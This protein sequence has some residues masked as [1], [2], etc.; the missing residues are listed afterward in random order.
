MK[1]VTVS[2]VLF[3]ATGCAQGATTPKMP[4][5]G[6]PPRAWRTMSDEPTPAGVIVRYRANHMQAL[7]NDEGRS[8]ALPRMRVFDAPDAAAAKA[9]LERLCKDPAIEA[10]EPDYRL[11]A[12]DLP[13]DPQLGAQ[14]GVPKMQVPEGWAHSTG[15]GAT[16]AVVDTGVHA[17][18]PDLG[19]QIIRGRDCVNDDDDPSDDH[20]HGTHVAGTIAALANNGLGGVG[21]APQS[22][23]L[24][25]KVLDQNGSGRTSD[26]AEG[27]VY[28]AEQGAKVINLSLG[29][30]QDSFALK[31]AITRAQ[32]A[33][34]LIVAAAGNDGTREVNYPAGYAGVIAVGASTVQDQRAR[35]SNHGNWVHIAAPGEG[36]LSTAKDGGYVKMSGT[37]MA[38]PHVAG[39]AALLS[40]KHPDWSATQL[41]EA[42][43]KAGDPVAGF[44]ANPACLR[45]NALKALHPEA[46]PSPVP[47]DDPTLEPV[48]IPSPLPVT[49]PTPLPMPSA[50]PTPKP[51]PSV[52]PT[53]QPRPTDAPGRPWIGPLLVTP[54][55][56]GSVTI[57]WQ[58]G[59]ACDGVLDYRAANANNTRTIVDARVSTS[60]QVILDGLQSGQ[61][62]LCRA[63]SNTLRRVVS[64]RRAFRAP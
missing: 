33:G 21:V 1:R 4:A 9:L 16:V 25:V 11:Q 3:L 32:R 29:S 53:L 62:Y 47:S 64:E 61:W 43:F 34:A 36:I 48:P 28:A 20:G 30:N 63:R 52:V 50:R 2:L 37:S 38:A 24:A 10:V 46:V 58:T 51:V 22:R 17:T 5:T 14:W 40:S 39:V 6:V 15:Q 42:L 18:H 41:R 13:N 23:V 35:F 7:G 27:V 56:P 31:E 49:S 19:G 8:L 54:G 45:L 26:I 55:A 60:H 12:F 44:E 57:S 59:V